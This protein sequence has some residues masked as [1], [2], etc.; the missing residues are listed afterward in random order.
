MKL[1]LAL[2]ATPLR[3]T[4]TLSTNGEFTLNTLLTAT[5]PLFF[6]TVKVLLIDPPFIDTTYPSKA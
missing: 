1:S 3:T 6:L 5:E 4:V 2:R